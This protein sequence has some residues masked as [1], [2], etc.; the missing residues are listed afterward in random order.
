MLIASG[1]AAI[2]TIVFTVGAGLYLLPWSFGYLGLY[3]MVA[4]VLL[5]VGAFKKKGQA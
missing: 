1:I 5:A 2:L 3:L 4:A